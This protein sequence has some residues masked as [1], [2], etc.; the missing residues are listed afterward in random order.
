MQIK[1]KIKHTLFQDS[2]WTRYLLFLWNYNP[3]INRFRIKK[4][5]LVITQSLLCGCRIVVHGTGNVIEI[6]DGCKLYGFSISI[7]G[8]N[9]KII[10]DKRVTG[11]SA[12]IC[13]EDDGNQIFI[14]KDTKFAGK[15]H[16]ACTEST[17]IRIGEDCLLSSEIVIRT[18][19]SHSIVDKNGNRINHAK[20]VEIGNH[21]WVGHRALIS[22]GSR[23]CDNSVVGTGA[24][25]TSCFDM[26][27]VV[28]AGVPAKVIS[29][30]IDWKYERV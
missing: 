7:T 10:L 8:N 5:R 19:D 2:A 27:G 15:I 17:Q 22:K 16:L 14:G 13:I 4:N 3:L 23:L 9:N 21:V 1:Q 25:V 6:A 26:Q 30:D 24:I 28:V 11:N 20:S 12:E 29:T 18:G